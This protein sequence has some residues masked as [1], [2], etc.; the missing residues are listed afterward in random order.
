MGSGRAWVE[1]RSGTSLLPA[2][3][4]GM[5]ASAADEERLRCIHAALGMVT[6]EEHPYF[7]TGNASETCRALGGT[8]HHC[9]VVGNLLVCSLSRV[10]ELSLSLGRPCRPQAARWCTSMHCHRS[11]IS[12]MAWCHLRLPVPDRAPAG[13][14]GERLG[15]RRRPSAGGDSTMPLPL[16][17]SEPSGSMDP[18]QTPTSPSAC[19]QPFPGHQQPVG[20]SLDGCVQVHILLLG[21]GGTAALPCGCLKPRLGRGKGC[22]YP[23]C[24]RWSTAA[25]ASMWPAPCCVLQLHTVTYHL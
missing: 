4:L 10:A 17:H 1:T 20:S 5:A 12:F 3:T 8:V 2:C 7:R 15:K 24:F 25:A 19:F 11:S 18:H 9:T 13:L 22:S 23:A 14:Q 6:R 21:S 16:F